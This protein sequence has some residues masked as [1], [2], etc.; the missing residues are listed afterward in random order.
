ML[1]GLCIRE[2]DHNDKLRLVN[3]QGLTACAL[4]IDHTAVIPCGRQK[5]GP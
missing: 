3:Q 5:I 2:T 1:H 4:G